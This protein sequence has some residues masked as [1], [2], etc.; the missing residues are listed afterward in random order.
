ML[1]TSGTL[2]FD[3]LQRVGCVFFDLKK[4]FD[5][6]PHQAL[7]D[8]LYS[9]H[10]PIHLFSWFSLKQHLLRVVLHDST[11]PWLPVASGV[12]QG[13]ILGPMFF[14][15]VLILSS[16]KSS[17]LLVYADDILLFKPLSSPSDMQ[18]LQDDVNRICEWIS[19]NHLTISMAKA[20]S[21]C[22]TSSHSSKLRFTILVNG[23][24]LEKVKCFKYLG[25]WIT[26]D[27]T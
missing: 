25:L 22:I 23:S 27:L 10:L 3:N 16:I 13:S 6:V 7:L 9:L 19:S 24:P 5:S 11:S 8:K 2:R 14:C 26:D 20:K 21:M 12:P 18:E 17:T 4:T 1:L 15:C